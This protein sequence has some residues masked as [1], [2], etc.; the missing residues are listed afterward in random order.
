MTQ[1]IDGIISILPFQF[2]AVYCGDHRCNRQLHSGR[3]ILAHLVPEDLLAA[4]RFAGCD[5]ARKVSAYSGDRAS[6]GSPMELS[7]GTW[8][9]E[10]SGCGIGEE[11]LIDGVTS[12]A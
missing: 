6:S 7:D 3:S 9:P 12:G 5:L 8:M 11:A 4:E 2:S 10:K 1:L